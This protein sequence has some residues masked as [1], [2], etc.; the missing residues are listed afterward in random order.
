MIINLQNT[1]AELAPAQRQFKLAFT[2]GCFDLLHSG[3]IY[4]LQ[5][6]R[7]KVGAEAKILVALHTDA[8]IKRIKGETR[9][10]FNESH[11]LALME[12]L[13]NVDYVGLW[14]GWENITDLVYQL[15]PEYLAGDAASIKRT[16]WENNWKKVATDIN[17]QLIGIERIEADLSTS[18]FI[19]KIKAL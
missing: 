18:K 14:H 2:S 8:D 17:A 5:R 12:G 3:H 10:I 7:E 1:V 9:P 6:L 15:K 11:R 4:F 16:D 13:K 19:E